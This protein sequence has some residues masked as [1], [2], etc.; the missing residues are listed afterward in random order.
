MNEVLVTSLRRC[1]LNTA[2]NWLW[3]KW[4]T[5]PCTRT[6]T[7]TRSHT[8]TDTHTFTHTHTFKHTQT[9]THVHT[10]RHRHTHTHIT[11]THVLAFQCYSTL[12]KQNAL[13]NGQKQQAECMVWWIKCNACLRLWIH[14]SKQTNTHTKTKQN[15]SNGVNLLVSHHRWM[16]GRATN[17][18]PPPPPP[19]PYNLK[20]TNKQT[21]NPTTT[22]EHL[23]VRVQAFNDI[24]H[25]PS[26]ELSYPHQ[27][28]WTTGQE[29]DGSDWGQAMVEKQVNSHNYTTGSSPQKA[30]TGPK[31]P[32]DG[33]SPGLDWNACGVQLYI[34]ILYTAVAFGF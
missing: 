6:H 14:D 8:H 27:E 29:Q 5:H 9:H 34:Y 25:S 18:P 3:T 30:R 11:H 31:F 22:K 28:Q 13:H 7:H 16:R 26:P 17:P 21:K 12:N 15:R 4:R 23:R 10:H 1:S 20:Q 19:N 24:S 33:S 2:V 32:T